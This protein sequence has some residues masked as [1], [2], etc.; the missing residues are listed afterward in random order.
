MSEKKRHHGDFSVTI[1]PPPPIWV[2]FLLFL[3]RRY[4]DR[5]SR[6]LPWMV[7]WDATTIG[8]SSNI[9]H[10]SCKAR[11]RCA[12]QN[13]IYKIAQVD[14]LSLKAMR[15]H[16]RSVV[17][18]VQWSDV[19]RQINVFV[20]FRHLALHMKVFTRLTK[21]GWYC[22]CRQCTTYTSVVISTTEFLMR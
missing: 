22:G 1:Q 19:Q 18:R 17:K 5:M 9:P 20:Q 16:S 15:S 8:V 10:P 6:W 11:A 21:K 12:L 14:Y 4:L 3:A 2:T 7:L 13:L